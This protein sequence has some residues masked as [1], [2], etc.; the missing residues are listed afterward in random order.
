MRLRNERGRR[1]VELRH[2]V[3]LAFQH[4]LSGILSRAL[5][6]HEYPNKTWKRKHFEQTLR[7]KDFGALSAETVSTRTVMVQSDDPKVL[8]ER[9]EVLSG[10]TMFPR[11]ESEREGLCRWIT[12]LRSH[13]RQGG[14]FRLCRRGNLNLPSSQLHGGPFRT[15]SNT[16]FLLLPI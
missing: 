2:C 14:S 16:A 10:N 1:F 15:S 12:D 8:A 3:E 7:K 13:S 4:E 9:T 5:G 11:S 6:V